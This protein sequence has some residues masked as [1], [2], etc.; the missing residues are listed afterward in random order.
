MKVI[1]LLFLQ[2]IHSTC[3]SLPYLINAISGPLKVKS[4]TSQ[5]K[6]EK[7]E[8]KKIIMKEIIHIDEN[9][10][11]W[12]D[13]FFDGV[14]QTF[15]KASDLLSKMK[16]FSKDED[17]IKLRDFVN[18]SKHKYLTRIVNDK[19]ALYYE[20][21]S[22]TIKNNN[23]NKTIKKIEKQEVKQFMTDCHDKIFPKIFDIYNC[24]YMSLKENL[25]K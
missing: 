14:K 13:Y 6:Q 25:M 12:N 4:K 2:N 23:G 8:C 1:L 21:F 9:R 22:Y 10:I 24:L 15:P 18:Q 5:C 3:D 7:N 19:K 17:F 11:G 16:K 20:E